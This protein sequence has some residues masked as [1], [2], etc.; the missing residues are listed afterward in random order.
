MSDQELRTCPFCGGEDIKV[1]CLTEY[2]HRDNR[3]YEVGCYGCGCNS[4]IKNSRQEAIEAW[5]RPML[6]GAVEALE[7]ISDGNGTRTN[8]HLRSIAQQ[9]L[10][11]LDVEVEE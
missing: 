1:E 8:K 6:D 10:S 7:E 4:G 2:K 3:E 11:D 5:N 9:A